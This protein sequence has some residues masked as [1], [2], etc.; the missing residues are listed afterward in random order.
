ME[1][2]SLNRDYG[3]VMLGSVDQTP[4]QQRIRI[5]VLL[6]GAVVTANVIGILI[7]VGL[8]AVGIPEPSTLR[9]DLAYVNFIA[10]PVYIL[11]ALIIGV[12]FGTASTVK[13]LRWSIN[14]EIPSREDARRSVRAV[15]RLVWMQGLLWV[16]GAAV[17]GLCYGLVDPDLIMKT[18]F[19]VLMCATVVVAIARLY[20]EILLRPVWAQILQAGL[21]LRGSSVRSRAIN[22]WLIG[23][24]I[25]LAGITLVLLFGVLRSD[26]SKTSILISVTVLAAVAA[27][28][29]LLTE[30]LFV[31]SIT[32]PLRSVRDGMATVRTGDVNRAQDIVVYDGS[33]LG[34]L[35]YGFNAMVSSLRE[36]ERM[37]DLFGRHVGRDVAAAA[38]RRDPQLGGEERV[39]AVVFVDVIGS[40]TI[41]EHRSPTEV[42][43]LLNKFFA[44][45]VEATERNGGLVNKFEGDAVLAIFGAPVDLDNSASSALVAAREISDGLHARVPELSAGVGVSFGSV[46]AGNVGAVQRFEYTVI[47]DPVNESARLSELAKDDPRYPVAALRAIDAAAQEEAA[48]WTPWREVTL[49]G[50]SEPTPVFV[51]R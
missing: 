34:E 20:T 36:Q 32:G 46:V 44:V 15:R 19:I 31:W 41:A 12:V 8:G 45:I 14:D 7:A 11:V 13:A 47:G 42:V 26:T 25:P 4:R 51:A 2:P 28:V 10:V 17:L 39:V 16:G 24:G 33:E 29:G 27:C 40:T 22:S 49:R 50:R 38:L 48:R 6:T 43:D 21:G 37:R 30:Y 23:T 9:W 3:S 5:Q 18:V 1:L 35:Q